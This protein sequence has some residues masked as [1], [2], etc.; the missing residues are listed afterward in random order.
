MSF[1]IDKTDRYTVIKL[2]VEKLDSNLAPSLKSE[3]VVLNTDGSK[4]IIIDLSNTRYCDSSGL[5]AILVAN[6]LCKNS[7]GVF[8][9]TGLQDPVRKLISISQLDTILNITDTLSEATEMLAVQV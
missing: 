8:V 2:T 6:R 9:L 4:N 1:Q 5:S 7:H 3:L